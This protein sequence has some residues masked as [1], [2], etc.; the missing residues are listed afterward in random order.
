M[1]DISYSTA[2][3]IMP[4]DA[5]TISDAK[6]DSAILSWLAASLPEGAQDTPIFYEIQAR[7]LPSNDWSTVAA[8]I[9]KCEHKLTDLLPEVEYLFRVRAKN[10][11]GDSD[12]TSSVK[13]KAR[14]GEWI[15]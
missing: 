9:E 11:F 10:E 7:Q 4:S 5:P 13:L 6:K 3:P 12:F 14:E 15:F 1:S 8:K 2:P